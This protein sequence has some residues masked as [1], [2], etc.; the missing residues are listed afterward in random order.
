M[1]TE[2]KAR[3]IK[4]TH[5]MRSTILETALLL[6]AFLLGFVPMWC[7]ARESA[8][9]LS[10]AEHHLKLAQIQNALATAAVD[11]Q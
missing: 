4:T 6:S 5:F 2:V 3:P 1:S 10:E 7:K 9:R 11:I 8:K